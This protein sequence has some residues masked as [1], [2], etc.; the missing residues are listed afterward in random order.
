M[1]RTITWKVV[2]TEKNQIASL[3]NATGLPIGD[4]ES[5]LII[6]G[7]LEN[8]KQKHLE[9]LNT[10]FEKTVKGSGKKDDLDL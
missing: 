2:L 1:T 10:L 9:K 7:L 6:I 8:L 4:V 5:H 3:E